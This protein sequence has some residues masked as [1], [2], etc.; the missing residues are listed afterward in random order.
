VSANRPDS[1][2]A[3]RTYQTAQAAITIASTANTNAAIVTCRNLMPILAVMMMANDIQVVDWD[4]F[5][6]FLGHR[7][8]HH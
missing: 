8:S 7:S 4:L 2:A 3:H 5:Y 6:G 1:G